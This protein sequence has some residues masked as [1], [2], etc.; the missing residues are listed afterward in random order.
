[1]I[2]WMNFADPDVG[3]EN[4]WSPEQK[5]LFQAVVTKPDVSSTPLGAFWQTMSDLMS[6]MPHT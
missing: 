6:G 2:R 5:A 4:K 1:M 3:T